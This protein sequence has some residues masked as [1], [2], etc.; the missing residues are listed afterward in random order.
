[1]R[2]NSPLGDSWTMMMMQFFGSVLYVLE[3]KFLCKAIFTLQ[4][5]IHWSR[6]AIFMV[7]AAT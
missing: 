6:D 2:L 1:M 7:Y 4:F 3:F 5:Q